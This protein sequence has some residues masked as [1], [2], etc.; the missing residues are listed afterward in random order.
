MNGKGEVTIRENEMVMLV[1]PVLPYS[2]KKFTPTS[3]TPQGLKMD[4]DG[5][6]SLDW[7][8]EVSVKDWDDLRAKFQ[9]GNARKAC[10]HSN[11][12]CLRS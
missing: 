9:M 1:H 4:S 5:F 11:L 6:K 10:L 8:T 3:R 12:T 7:V 2:S